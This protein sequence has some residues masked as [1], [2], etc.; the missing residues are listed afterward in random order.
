MKLIGVGLL[1]LAL[2]AAGCVPS[3]QDA[4]GQEQKI[5]A[6]SGKQSFV[7]SWDER[8]G[9]NGTE[10]TAFFRLNPGFALNMRGS[11]TK[12]LNS[13][14]EFVQ[15][16][17]TRRQIEVRKIAFVEDCRAEGVRRSNGTGQCF[18]Y[19]NV[20]VAE[21][22]SL[23]TGEFRG[24]K[25]VDGIFNKGQLIGMYGKFLCRDSQTG[26]VGTFEVS[27]GSATMSTHAVVGCDIAGSVN[28]KFSSFVV[29]KPGKPTPRP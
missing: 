9:I 26:K 24:D 15:A 8:F 19:G 2:T 5:V 29:L 10:W 18:T 16:G 14:N 20:V 7:E 1:A 22:I 6:A 27:P 23:R 21:A 13:D 12:A 25:D 17:P 28:G 3:S 4:G 11:K